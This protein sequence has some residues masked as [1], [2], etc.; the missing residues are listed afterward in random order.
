MKR[1]KAKKFFRKKFRGSKQIGFYNPPRKWLLSSKIPYIVPHKY[2][3]KLR[4]CEEITLQPLA[5]SI[6][7]YVFSANGLYDPNITGSGH[8]P[9]GFDQ[10]ITLFSLYRVLWSKIRVSYVDT[11]ASNPTPM[12]YTVSL[13]GTSAATYTTVQAMLE[14]AERG[15]TKNIQVT[16]AFGGPLDAQADYR[17]FGVQAVY[18]AK[19]IPKNAGDQTGSA[20]INPAEQMYYVISAASVGGNTPSSCKFLVEIDYIAEFSE[21]VSQ[22]T[23]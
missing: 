13:L 12:Y 3:C 9:N 14:D 2:R 19:Y 4:Y 5:N 22:Q 21:P 1:I 23:S 10:L 6:T 20:T 7:Q 17:K 16:G 11:T 15:A 18:K 8:Q